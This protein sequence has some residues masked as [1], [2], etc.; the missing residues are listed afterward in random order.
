MYARDTQARD[1]ETP[2]TVAV[3]RERW[4]AIASIAGAG[5]LVYLAWRMLLPFLP[6]LCWA[7]ALAVISDPVYIW[8]AK[9]LRATSLAA[10]V[11]VVLILT[12]III[13][14][15]LVGKALLDE[16]TGIVQSANIDSAQIRVYLER[17]VF[18]G[19]L[20]QWVDARVDLA[21]ATAD[22]LRSAVS[23]LSQVLSFLLAGSMRFLAQIGVT[24][25]ALFYFLRDRDAILSALTRLLPVPP[26]ALDRV[27]GR[28]VD[29]I[30]ISLGGKFVTSTI[31]GL[32]GGVI[33]AWVG[34]P[35]PIFW[36]FVM[37]LLSL[38]PVI[39][40]FLVWAP[41]ALFLFFEGDWRHAVLITVW[42]V[43]IIHP[44]DNLLGP[45]LVGTTLRLHTLVMFF[46]ILGGL[47]AFG[48]AGIVIGPLVTAVVVSIFEESAAGAIQR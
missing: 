40:A 30:R 27:F 16:I 7:F 39:G 37:G 9:R 19:P 35:A 47:A 32:L 42:G 26:G 43:V 6:A 25:F 33:F 10:I 29:M 28:I 12:V 23:S 20:F 8:L 1:T 11:T 46:S 2:P 45:I 41:A 14:S 34:L 44:V 22:M 15:T 4:R 18:V 48:A 21:G 3:R 31:Q 5:I 38:F 17:T 13:P 24:I 36:G